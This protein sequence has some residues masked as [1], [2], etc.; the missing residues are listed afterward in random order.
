MG[1]FELLA[2]RGTR[3]ILRELS[4]NKRVKYSDLVKVVGFS[5][6]TTRALKAMEMEEFVGKEVMNEPYRPV[7][8]FLTKRGERLASLVE[9]L[10]KV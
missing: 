2:L 9:Q 5:T 10:E 7:V 4:K 1:L 6:T 8:Y 3:T